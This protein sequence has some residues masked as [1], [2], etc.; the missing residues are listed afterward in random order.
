MTTAP[1]FNATTKKAQTCD[2]VRAVGSRMK[3]AREL[4]NLSQV[5]AARRLGYRNSS[6]LS[7]VES[8]SDTQSV[9]MLLVV[10]AA[11]LYDVSSDYLLGLSDDWET[12]ARLSQERAVSGWLFEVW[13][14]TRA[15]DML[16]LRRLNDRLEA[17]G[18]VIS[19]MCN[20]TS[21]TY[22]MVERVREINPGFDD[23]RAGN[24]L[25]HCAKSAAE[26]AHAARLQ[27]HRLHLQCSAK[28][29]NTEQITM[30]L[31]K[32]QRVTA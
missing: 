15:R 21:E 6:K 18:S 2:L 24:R 13:E 7:K 31:P 25:L 12:D 1:T 30:D 3:A 27:M 19:T 10:K 9:P 32:Q 16:I 28:F 29:S 11:K 23:L 26:A 14:N 17:M 8:A 5:E 22:S 20:A 4:C